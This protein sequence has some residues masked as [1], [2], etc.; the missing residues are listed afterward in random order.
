MGALQPIHLLII[1]A[2]VVLLFGGAKIPQLMRGVGQGMGEFKKGLKEGKEHEDEAPKRDELAERQ[3]AIE[4]RK[5]ELAREE[6]EL[7]KLKSKARD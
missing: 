1:L 7:E 5:Q 2:I 4:A 6:A 3:K